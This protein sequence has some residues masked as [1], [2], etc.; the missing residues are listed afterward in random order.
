MMC[1]GE[2]EAINAEQELQLAAEKQ[3]HQPPCQN[4]LDSV[5]KLTCQSA[6]SMSMSHADCQGEK[7]REHKSKTVVGA[8]VDRI[9][10]VLQQES[11]TAMQ[12]WYAASPGEESSL[13][14]MSW[15]WLAISLEQIESFNFCF[16]PL[17]SGHALHRG[18][19]SP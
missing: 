18:S 2:G 11:D 7:E 4:H 5:R 3:A 8:L 1:E 14:N 19:L 17:A 13:R 9:H 6:G 12:Q 15:T 16:C 10:K